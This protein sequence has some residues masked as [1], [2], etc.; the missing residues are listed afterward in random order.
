[1]SLI[2]KRKREKCRKQKR[3]CTIVIPFNLTIL[4]KLDKL[5]LK[6]TWD[7]LETLNNPFL[8]Q[9]KKEKIR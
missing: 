8:L 9:D 1:M 4:L 5:S 6:L 2:E 3:N 7:I